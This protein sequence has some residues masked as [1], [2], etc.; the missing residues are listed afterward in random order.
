ML[1]LRIPLWLAL[2]GCVLSLPACDKGGEDDEASKDDKDEGAKADDGGK[3]GAG[4]AKGD[5]AAAKSAG[6]AV[7]AA[8]DEAEAKAGLDIL[9]DPEDKAFR[10]RACE[11]LT[12]EMVAETFHVP[13]GEL[14]QHKMMGCIYSWSKDDLIVDA[15]V[16]MPR[17][18]K[19]LD[20]AKRWFT[21]ATA[22]KTAEE[23][24]AGLEQAKKMVKKHE[25]VDTKMKKKVAGD[26][27]DIA[28]L[29]TPDG[30]IT[31]TDVPG[32][33][34]EARVSEADGVMW[35]RLGNLTFQ[36]SGYKGS[37][38]PQAK[39]DTKNPKGMIKESM[40]L[41]KK[42]IKDTLDQR[43]EASAKLAPKVVDAVRKLQAG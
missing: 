39:L 4:A 18:H 43:K 10:K 13:A 24:D 6:E 41:R 14:K 42:W 17:V 19:T 28:K 23:I 29:G 21:N 25:A 33:G 27:T 12:P 38:Q 35:V 1:M 32:V 8:V 22:T 30:G 40:A 7:E 2:T 3:G 11:F 37:P 36:V 9:F 20:G 34:D 26:L 16:M 5:A 31:Y 15:N